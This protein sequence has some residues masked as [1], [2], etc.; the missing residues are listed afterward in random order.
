MKHRILIVDDSEEIHEL[1]KKII[2]KMNSLELGLEFILDH[3]YQGE[4]AVLK[5]R[6]SH[7]SGSPYSFVMMDI[8]MPPG[9]DGIETIEKVQVDHP[10]TEFIVC[11]AF[12]KYDFKTLFQKFGATDRIL[13]VTKPY[14]PTTMKQLTLYICSKFER[15][16]K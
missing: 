8:R 15:E 7:K 13:Y 9:I 4:V 3:C 1:Y 2:A 16:N 6:E 14:N 11:T 12:H 5:V 10:D